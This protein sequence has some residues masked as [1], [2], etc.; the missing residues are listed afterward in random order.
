MKLQI[1]VLAALLTLSA[2]A[3]PP[4]PRAPQP[5]PVAKPTA[6]APTP[7]PQRPTG[8]WIDWPVAPG[9][10]MYRR[11]DR[12]SIALFGPTG[13]NATLTLRCDAQR[14]R[15]YL[16]REGSGPG[17]RMVVRT[18]SAMKELLAS[19]TSG[20]VAYLAT[21]IMPTDPILDA[22]ALSRGRIAVE[23]EGQQPIAIPSWAEITR[24]VE[25]CRG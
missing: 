8:E 11:D 16:A 12:G 3:S 5:A 22:M 9:D 18:N 21:E 17:G 14:R 13:Q 20:T 23:A 24:I 25:D 6:V 1:P 10:W 2:C 7:Q 19:P 15:V 4:A